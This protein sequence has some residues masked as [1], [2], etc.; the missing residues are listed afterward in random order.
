[1]AEKC[2]VVYD[3]EY[4][5]WEGSLERNWSGPDEEAEIIQIGAILMKFNA[6]TWAIDQ[7]FVTYVKP[8][9]RP[10][11]SSYITKLTGITQKSIDQ[12]GISFRSALALFFEFS[13]GCTVLCANGD[14]SLVLEKNCVINSLVSPFNQNM[15]LDV[16]PFVAEQLGMEHRD[17]RAQSHRLREIGNITMSRQHDALND[18]RSVAEFLICMGWRI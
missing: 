2:V 12:E 7:E 18:A 8:L 17:S 11:L 4:T 14:D 5:A 1:M 10:K 3:L 15:F 16:R 9:I 13:I 6:N